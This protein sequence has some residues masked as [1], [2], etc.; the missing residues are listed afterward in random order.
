MQFEQPKF[1]NINIEKDSVK[2]EKESAWENKQ[3][4]VEYRTDVLGHKIDEQIKETVVALNIIGLPTSASCEGHIDHGISAPWIEVSAPNEPEERFIGQ[5]EIFKKIANKYGISFEDIER[6]INHD[7]WAEALKESSQNDETPEYKQ[8]REENKKLMIR[9]SELLKKFY[10]DREV[11]PNIKLQILKNPEGD[12]RIINGGED[13]RPV[14]DKLTAEQKNE[15][16][17]RL[18]LCQE[19]MK[20]FAAFLKDQYLSET[21]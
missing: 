14:P 19:E 12:F 9:V 21:K 20:K 3:K 4:E 17:Q 13:Y 18:K 16:S 5:K 2:S 1:E 6:G 7:A 15:L 11:P 10:R 8:W